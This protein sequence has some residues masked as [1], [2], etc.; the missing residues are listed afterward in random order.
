[1][2]LK[3]IKEII[4]LVEKSDFSSFSYKDGQQEIKLKKERQTFSKSETPVQVSPKAEE[5][6]RDSGSYIFSPMVGT[7]YSASSPDSSPFVKVGDE[8][9]AGQCVGVIEAMK[10]MNEVDAEE[11]AKIVS[12][13]V[14]DG[15]NV[16]YGQPL[17][18]IEKQQ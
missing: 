11:N 17:F 1:M 18:Q 12:A 2:D 13:L 6:A 7:F 9:K 14:K 16:E 8:V 15:Q 5:S 4:Q 3:D 10:M